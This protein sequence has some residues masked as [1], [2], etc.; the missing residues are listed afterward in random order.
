M[1]FKCIYTNFR[2]IIINLLGVYLPQQEISSMLEI[3]GYDYVL[4][5]IYI[6]KR[7]IMEKLFWNIYI[8][9][10]FSELLSNSDFVAFRTETS[11]NLERSHFRKIQQMNFCPIV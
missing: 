7:N 6:L 2:E 5:V 4:A 11:K 3:R 10:I 8:L 9:Y 1:D